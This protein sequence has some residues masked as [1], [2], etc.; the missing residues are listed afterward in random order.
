MRRFLFLITL[1]AC[2]R[3]HTVT[4]P[5]APR[6]SILLVTL[7]T[8]RDDAIGPEAK[9]VETPAYNALIKRGLRFRYAYATVPQTL[10][11]HASMLT[12]LYPAGHGVHENGRYLA[13]NQPLVTERLH[14]AGYRTAAFVSAFALARRFGLA[15]GF[16]VYD[17]DFGEGKAERP[18]KE[19][20]DR[21]IKYLHQSSPQPLF[22]WVHYYDPHFPYTPPEPFKTKYAKQPYFGEVAF[23][24]EELGRLVDAFDKQVQGPKAFVIV[25]DHG[26]GLGDHG[27]AQHGDLLYQATV[28]VPLLLIGPGITPGINDAPVSTRRI[29]HTILDW[30][31]LDATNT[32][33]RANQ[34]VVVG[35]AM[36]PF[37]DYGWQPQ[38][39]AV[40]GRLKTI[41]AGRTEVYDVV[42]DPGETRH[43]GAQANLSRPVRAALHEYPIPSPQTEQAAN[44]LDDE[45]RRKLA[46]LGYVASTVKPV[47]RADAP[48][49]AEMTRLFAI[50]DHVAALFVREQYAQCIPLLERILAE[51]PHNL[52]AALRL[53]TAHSSL[54]HDAQA[55]AAFKRAEA[56]APD[57]QDVRTYLALHYTRT[58]DWQKAVPLLERIVAESPDRLPALEALAVVRERQR[59]IEDA[60]S[61]RQRIY[62]L[63]TASPAELLQ[64]AE[65]EMAIGQTDAAIATF[66]RLCA[67]QGAAFKNNLELGVLYLAARR[68]PEARDALDRVPANDP[69]YAMALFKRAQVSVLL[70]EAE[71]PSRIETARQH[72]TP[73]TRELIAR[74]RLFQ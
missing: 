42:A 49:P 36:K 69:G 73:L 58:K 9:N 23:M 35:E 66:E 8:T 63:R 48:R 25:A 3:A 43:L 45:G 21:V 4:P 61:L 30:A 22:L 39:M 32:L 33:R 72:A 2:Q 16:D 24:D 56:I 6:P 29:F 18:A 60:V 20:T 40:E 50:L 31:G 41:L 54:G 74:E 10:A 13:E 28:H 62:A 55:L 47:V 7:D 51:D 34:E 67:V 14:S 17:E 65:M 68:L 1:I 57:S 5:P 15:R 44:N 53:A 38:V 64:L 71:A 19:T 52:D 46:S 27:E 59:R 12:G 37:L 26:E 11:S 70:H